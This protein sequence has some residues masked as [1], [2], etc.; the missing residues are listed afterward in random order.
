MLIIELGI[1][2]GNDVECRWRWFDIFIGG[3]YY[4]LDDEEGIFTSFLLLFYAVRKEGED[5]SSY[6]GEFCIVRR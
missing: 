3:Q 4:Q 1:I 5:I 2:S 6:Q